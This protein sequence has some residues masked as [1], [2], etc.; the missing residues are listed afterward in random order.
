MVS[1]IPGI[2][3][4]PLSD[5]YP[6]DL[7]FQRKG[8]PPGS[9]QYPLS[10][11]YPC[12]RKARDAAAEK[13]GL[14]YPLSDRYPCDVQVLVHNELINSLAV[15][16]LG[17]IP[18]RRDRRE[19]KETTHYLQYPLSDRYPCDCQNLSRFAFQQRT[20]SILSRIDTP[21]TVLIQKTRIFVFSCSILSRI[22]TPATLR[23]GYASSSPRVLAVSSLGSI[24]LRRCNGTTFN[25]SKA[26]LQYPL[27]DRYPCD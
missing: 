7:F 17:S 14:Q 13:P 5:R 2:L 25:G 4:Y 11:R 24:P 16:S 26:T 8:D 18:L 21:A 12:D 10:D 1:L 6:C 23:T 19:S 15:S 9:L 20:C 3:Q 22:D 27:S